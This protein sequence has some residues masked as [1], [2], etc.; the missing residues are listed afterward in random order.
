MS[1]NNGRNGEP[2]LNIW[3]FCLDPRPTSDDNVGAP[4]IHIMETV[5]ALRAQGHRVEHFLYGDA[6]RQT[7]KSMRETARRFSENNRLFRTV[8]P[9]LRDIYELY[10]DKQDIHLI[11]PIFQN[12]PIDLAYERLSQHKSAVSVC[13][14]KY[15]V[16][17]IVESN[18]PVEERREYWGAPLFRV[19]KRLEKSI[20]QRADAVTAV[21]SPLKRYYE[22]L[23]IEAAKIHV[24]PNGVNPERFSPSRLSCDVRTELGL[25]NNVVVGFVG[26]I[27]PYHGIELF[28]P[29]ARACASSG[30]AIHSLVIGAGPGRA[31]LQSALENE[32]LDE[33]FTFI[34]PIPNS[35]VPNYLAAMDICILPRFMWYGSPM[36]VLEYGA[37]G[38]AIVAPNQEN[39]RDILAHG[40]TALLFEPHNTDALVQAVQELVK[41]EQ[42]RV[43]LGK[44]ARQHILSKH[45]WNKN[46]ERIVEIYR[47]AI[48]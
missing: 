34:D 1:T 29:L 26:N 2:A 10:L 4:S 14:Q 42:L 46:A 48:A 30:S 28:L 36:K 13:T 35:E 9:L 41:D 37:M 25:N 44:S 39:I 33:T 15:E 5:R 47:E 21:S 31:D 38:K 45:A 23:G 43:R 20:L 7:E 24:L 16:P 11:E 12:N 17:L 8:K 6:L 19:T 22:Q 32:H 18:A 3:Y 40:E 27:F